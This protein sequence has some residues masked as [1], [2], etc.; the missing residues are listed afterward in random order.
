MSKYLLNYI[1]NQIV[2]RNSILIKIITFIFCVF[3]NEKVYN[4]ITIIYPIE[5]PKNEEFLNNDFDASIC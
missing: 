4:K 2:R 5:A 3:L 1:P